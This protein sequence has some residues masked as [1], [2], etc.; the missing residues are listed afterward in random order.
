MKIFRKVCCMMMTLILLTQ[1][2]PVSALA[3]NVTPLT[4]PEISALI[5]KAGMTL[6]EDSEGL[7][8]LEAETSAYH[9]GMTPEDGWSIRMQ[10]DW[11][12]DLLDQGII[13]LTNAYGGVLQILAGL[14]TSDPA[15][16]AR[17]TEGANAEHY[18][19]ALEFAHYAET[20]EQ[21]A[22]FLL[23]RVNENLSLIEQ[24]VPELL[25][26]AGSL[27]EH[28]ILAM[29]QQLRSAGEE[30]KTLE[31]EI[32]LLGLTLKL[33]DADWGRDVLEGRINPSL[34]AWM[35]EVHGELEPAQK[36][37][38]PLTRSD[39]TGS[40]LMGRLSPVSRALADAPSNEA[41]ILVL[42]KHQMAIVI[43]NTNKEYVEGVSVTVTDLNSPDKQHPITRT[44][45]T[46]KHGTQ[47]DAVVAAVFNCSDFV[48][49]FEQ[50]MELEI[51]ADGSEMGYRS[52]CI[53][54]ALVK[55]GGHR[56]E[57]LTKTTEPLSAVVGQEN[58]TSPYVYSI[59]F[60]DMDIWRTDKVIRISDLN[61]LSFDFAIEVENPL[62]TPY[63]P[64]EL[65]YYTAEKKNAATTSSGG[66]V[67][68]SMKPTSTQKVTETRTRYIYNAQWKRILS[69]DVTREQWPCFVFPTTGYRQKTLAS[70]QRSKLDEPI[71][72]GAEKKSNLTKALSSGLGL[73]VNLPNNLG[74]LNLNIPGSNFI[75]KVMTDSYGY[76]TVTF[77][78]SLT[79]LG[80]NTGGWK[81]EEQE[82]YDNYMKK[83][84]HAIS[85]AKQKQ[86]LGTATKYYKK[87]FGEKRTMQK[88]SFDFGFF[89]MITGKNEAADDDG[90]SGWSADG[91]AGAM[92]TISYDM[93][94][95][96][97]LGPIP[98]YANLNLCFSAG[99]GV[100]VGYRA[101]LDRNGNIIS[102]EFDLSGLTIQIR[103]QL[104]ATLGIGI[105]GI[106]SVWVAASGYLNIALAFVRNQPMHIAVSFGA[107]LSV[108]AEIFFISYSKV[109]LEKEP[110][111]IYENYKLASPR[112][113]FWLAAALADEPGQKVDTVEQTPSKY[114]RLAPM[115]TEETI[116]RSSNTGLTITLA[117]DKI[118][119]ARIGDR[120]VYF[121]LV[122]QSS[123]LNTP[124]T[125]VQFYDP[126]A[127]D[128]YKVRT[129]N[130]FLSDTF[131]SPDSKTYLNEHNGNVEVERKLTDYSAY[132]YDVY[133][134]GENLHI[135]ILLT[136]NDGFD[137]NHNQPL[138]SAQRLIVYTRMK[139][140][141]GPVNGATAVF[142]VNK[143]FT[144]I[145]EFSFEMTDPRI[146]YVEKIT[147]GGNEAFNIYGSIRGVTE[148][149][150]INLM[151]YTQYNHF[152]ITSETF[153]VRGDVSVGGEFEDGDS[154]KYM[155]A[156]SH[157]IM[158]TA[159]R[160]VNI[161]SATDK[162]PTQPYSFV[163]LDTP[164]GSETGDSYLVLYDNRVDRNGASYEENDKNNDPKRGVHRESDKARI[165]PVI[166]D[167]GRISDFE[168]LQTPD[169]DPNKCNL[170]IFY[171]KEETAGNR[172]VNRLKGIT[173]GPT[174]AQGEGNNRTFTNN[175]T[176]TDY[177]LSLPTADFKVA[178]IGV[179]QYL[180]WVSTAPKENKNDPDMWRI[181][182]VY[183]DNQTDSMSD[184]LVIAEFSLPTIDGKKQMPLDVTLTD[185]GTGY[186]TARSAAGSEDGTQTDHDVRLYSFP[187]SLKAAGEL[188]GAAVMDT[189]AMQGETL[190]T[191]L[192][193]LNVGN[194]G[195][196]TFIIDVYNLAEGKETLVE[197]LYAN[198]LNPKDSRIV[199]ADGKTVITGE[200]AFFRYK[201]F[202]YSPRSH[203][204]VVQKKNRTFRTLK[205]NASQAEWTG[206]DSEATHVQTNVLV[207]GALGGYSTNI[208]IP[209]S[210][211]GSY[212]LRLKLREVSTYANWL[213][214]SKLAKEHPQL[215][216]FY[217]NQDQ[218]VLMAW[219]ATTLMAMA[220][221]STTRAGLQRMVYTLDE[222][223]GK[224]VLRDPE[225]FALV[226]ASVDWDLGLSAA[227]RE[228][229]TFNSVYTESAHEGAVPLYPYPTEIDASEPMEVNVEV[230]DIDVGHRMYTDYSGQEQLE[231]TVH[232]HYQ[233]NQPM[234]LYCTVYEDDAQVGRNFNLPH[235]MEHV[236]SGSTQTITLP[237]AAL[238]DP[239]KHGRI[240]VVI[241]GIGLYNETA[242][243]NNEFEIYTGGS[244][245]EPSP[246]SPPM[247][248]TGDAAQPALWL[249]LLG[250]GILSVTA[251]AVAA[252]RKK[253]K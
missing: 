227:D 108:G 144:E 145:Y 183:Y 105:K 88:L 59:S 148:Q 15:A 3:E 76:V 206:S 127:E 149:E 81:S 86:R 130:D 186:I 89:V 164:K 85:V 91:T 201:D 223:R 114:P 190:A 159:D 111:M 110:T 252:I 56:T 74:T 112:R 121:S 170:K 84:Q 95:P 22:R 34:S 16:Y 133:D 87:M 13:S 5:S 61:N 119:P 232:N 28:E 10:I 185:T 53:P 80:K 197:T 82:K 196:G 122:K 244:P 67:E 54:W 221:D 23:T 191:D 156:E 160:D 247:P 214:A 125:Y 120:N 48:G 245:E 218:P 57:I 140:I 217:K 172:T 193:M 99:I 68:R 141:N 184:E 153:G 158:R 51:R 219:N 134:D 128:A 115:A 154:G 36:E 136:K 179:S 174:Q 72:N 241:K 64:P 250:I 237:L 168:M 58:Q 123:G 102:S 25:N 188:K 92:V 65:H 93:T 157:T 155:R 32:L 52:F 180:Y 181:S 63:A 98:A 2:V 117:S 45:K 248:V 202:I 107:Y 113:P 226:R 199:M 165:Q 44:E 222:D 142:V 31:A 97:M 9:S 116:M 55:K 189:V 147:S 17:L 42:N 46:A 167:Q 215:F 239:E 249:I 228:L 94:A 77:G 163:A 40:T 152:M 69:P 200:A 213:Y 182:G 70:P 19:N 90:T 131:P 60:N 71:F 39:S 29:S 24:T 243:F 229:L 62:N 26:D 233:S 231:I 106:L 20:S 78:S 109:L 7:F 6:K 43:Q 49:D 18:Q 205:A 104:T 30:M 246:T 220:G 173:V 79:E 146:E 101:M 137:T 1:A 135:I 171:M 124:Y 129:M 209:D 236:S 47:K 166:L 192:T 35:K 38:V 207:P 139:S 210:W 195:I 151:E 162:E 194:M 187:I 27:F 73:G 240:R 242:T 96:F 12:N 103:L 225:P 235:S 118:R 208:K 251:L 216:A 75:P 138:P 143:Y 37:E 33:G 176:Y 212:R 224:M 126:E 11:L 253:R 204:W 198:C 169:A 132:D 175:A 238:A 21:Q 50:N 234:R 41:T 230:H 8:T 177:D 4:F 211:E 83:Y 161:M 203:E 14:E 150:D 178:T 100:S 66:A